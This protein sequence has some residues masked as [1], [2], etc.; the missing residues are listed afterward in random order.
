MTAQIE[1][2]GCKARKSILAVTARDLRLRDQKA[3]IIIKLLTTFVNDFV[4]PDEATW[5]AYARSE[6][7]PQVMCRLEGG[8]SRPMVP[9]GGAYPKRGKKRRKSPEGRSAANLIQHINRWQAPQCK[10]VVSSLRRL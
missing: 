8:F 5:R 6:H 3:C 9:H 1:L 4:V 10:T 7:D 2:D